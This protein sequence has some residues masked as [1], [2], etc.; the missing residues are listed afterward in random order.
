MSEQTIGAQLAA[1]QE[2]QTKLRQRLDDT[3]QAIQ[4]L[5]QEIEALLY[6][7]TIDRAGELRIDIPYD[8]ARLG[9]LR[10]GLGRDWKRLG[11]HVNAAGGDLYHTYQFRRTQVRLTVCLRTDLE[12]ATC[13]KVK[14]GE[15]VQ[16][17]YEIVCGG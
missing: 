14:V 9:A 7:R 11:Q 16:P 6:T 5:P 13:R 2:H 1:L 4:T 12:G 15:Q 17:I 8:P 3:Q 10:F